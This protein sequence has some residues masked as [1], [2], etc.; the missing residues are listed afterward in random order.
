VK[1]FQAPVRHSEKVKSEFS[2]LTGGKISI[3][4][5]LLKAEVQQQNMR[6]DWR[7]VAALI[8]QESKFKPH[9][10]SWAGAFGLMQ[11][12]PRTASRYGLTEHSSPEKNVRAGIDKLKRLDQHWSKFISYEPTRIK[13]ILA[14]YNA[15]L[16]HVQDACRLAEVMGKNPFLWDGHVDE[17]LLLKSN[18]K[19]F[20]NPVVRYGYC[21]GR[22]PYNYVK[23]ILNRYEQYSELITQ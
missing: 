17:C 21:R 16:G 19:Y 4:D 23:E 20:T 13:F 6:W 22:E 12:M 8:Y 1:Y 7:L 14:S 2:S 3:Y 11:L 15:G 9:A 10:K 18:P 5:S